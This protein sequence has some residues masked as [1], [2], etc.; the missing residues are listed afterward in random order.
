MDPT[1]P[2][3]AKIADKLA[4]VRSKGHRSSP[5]AAARTGS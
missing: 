5:T 4:I 3:M 2:E 1:N